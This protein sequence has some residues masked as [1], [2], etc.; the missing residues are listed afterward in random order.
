[1]KKIIEIFQ[2]SHEVHT[3]I[4]LTLF[5]LVLLMIAAVSF[6]QGRYVTGI[7]SGLAFLFEIPYALII[8]GVIKPEIKISESK[9]SSDTVMR[10]SQLEDKLRAIKKRIEEDR[11]NRDSNEQGG[12]D[13]SDES[14]SQGKYGFL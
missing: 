8:L 5:P 1:M 4:H 13:E 10:Q 12:P 6:T 3:I 2:K 11:L 7:I 9:G 14:G